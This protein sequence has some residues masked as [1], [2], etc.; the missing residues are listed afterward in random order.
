M[1]L[2]TRTK[3]LKTVV[4]PIW[5]GITILATWRGIARARF[6]GTNSPMIMLSSVA[7]AIDTTVAIGDTAARGTASAVR[8]GCRKTLNAG[9]S[10]K[11]VSRVVSVM[12]S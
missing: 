8:S 10:V 7:M 3:G 6:L 4:K 11:P 9:S 12:P 1:P 5:N 2:S